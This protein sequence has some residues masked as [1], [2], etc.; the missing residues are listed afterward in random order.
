MSRGPALRYLRQFSL[1]ELFL[2]QYNPHDR[3]LADT[4]T[5]ADERRIL[6]LPA[7]GG[8]LKTSRRLPALY[9]AVEASC[10]LYSMPAGIFLGED[11]REGGRMLLLK[12][13]SVL[14]KTH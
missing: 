13:L 6:E 9:I 11:R 5:A 2:S 3:E 14:I 10:A 7:I 1:D 12:G 4:R 8:I